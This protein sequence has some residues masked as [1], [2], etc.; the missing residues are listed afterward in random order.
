MNHKNSTM[1]DPSIMRIIDKDHPRTGKK[2]RVWPTYDFGT[3]VMDGLEGVT[4]RFRSKE[5]EM[6]DE[7]QKYIQKIL[8]F[9]ETLI[10]EIARFN[11][12]GVPSSGRIIRQMIAEGQLLGWD[13]PRL[14]TLMALRRRGFLPE[15][16]KE[17]L[18]STGISKTESTL[19]WEMLESFNRKHL[20]KKANR[21]FAVLDPVE[22]EIDGLPEKVE[23]SLHPEYP[24]R[25]K[26][27]I[28]VG[29]VVYISRNDFEKYK[30]K[31]IRLI[32]LCN[33][34]LKK[35]CKNEG[36]EILHEM[37]KIHWVSEPNVKIK[38]LMNDGKIVEMIAEPDIK[39]VE[40]WAQLI[41]FG[42]VKLESKEK[43]LFVF[44]HP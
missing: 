39:K 6:R 40:G 34:I 15:A 16:I 22:I 41:R 14:T 30:G 35:K 19:T 4:H 38:V 20:D 3:A 36:N 24:E 8:G 25:G 27:T 11:L 43:M 9:K 5:F 2:Y 10:Q 44:T 37:P 42:F 7:L 17:F 26:R 12:E 28:P 18:V 1:R 33:V 21:F 32:G 29:K 31:K 23:E 13:D